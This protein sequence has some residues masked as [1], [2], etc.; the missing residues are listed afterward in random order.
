MKKSPEAN[1]VITS[2]KRNQY[3]AAIDHMKQL[4][5]MNK[6]LA[7]TM[8]LREEIGRLRR[9]AFERTEAIRIE[10]AAFEREREKFRENFESKISE[11]QKNIE[12]QRKFNEEMNKVLEDF[13]KFRDEINKKKS[14]CTI[15]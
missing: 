9:E 12:E 4:G 5:I 13:Q 1:E 7:E 3:P 2:Y 11:L 15:A 10:T 6:R 8:Y 14:K